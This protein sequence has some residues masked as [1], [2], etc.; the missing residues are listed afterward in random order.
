MQLLSQ[1][2]SKRVNTIEADEKRLRKVSIERKRIE[3]EKRISEAKES[4][5]EEKKKSW[6]EFCIFNQKLQQQKAL[7]IKEVE[8]LE[9]KRERIIETIKIHI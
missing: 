8:E 2:N 3:E 7:L 9:A 4:W 6:Q 5:D 1:Q